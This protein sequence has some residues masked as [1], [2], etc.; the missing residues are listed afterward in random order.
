MI[1][2]LLSITVPD[3][4]RQELSK[5]LVS[6]VG[7]IRVQAGCLS[8]HVVLTWPVQDVLRMEARWDSQEHLIRHLRSGMFKQLLQL[9]ELS[10]APPVLEFFTV[11]EFRGLDLV[12]AARF[13]PD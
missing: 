8:C 5:A 1:I 3:G 6:F 9:M 2:E 7:P 4:K 11:I 12:E 13:R 10:A